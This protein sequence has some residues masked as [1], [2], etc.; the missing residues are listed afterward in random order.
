MLC[1]REVASARLPLLDLCETDEHLAWPFC[2]ATPHSQHTQRCPVLQ[3]TLTV[4]FTSKL[5]LV[6]RSYFRRIEQQQTR[7][8][9][10]GRFLQRGEKGDFKFQFGCL[11]KLVLLADWCQRKR[12]IG[13]G[14]M[15]ST[16]D[17]TT[18]TCTRQFPWQGLKSTQP[19]VAN[20]LWNKKPYLLSWLFGKCFQG[21]TRKGIW[22]RVAELFLEHGH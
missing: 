17:L 9:R 6:Q 13:A 8:G 7:A 15:S 1:A 22:E 3:A 4:P 11:S 2:G 20:L 21:E 14:K 18:Y 16:E 12:P 19:S 10:S 5:A